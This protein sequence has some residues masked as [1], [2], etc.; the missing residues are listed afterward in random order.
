[1]RRYFLNEFKNN[2]TRKART[3][4]CNSLHVRDTNQDLIIHKFCKFRNVLNVMH[5]NIYLNCFIELISQC[6][7]KY[8]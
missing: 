5:I 6:I 3:Y 1:M 4:I 2:K 7:T 8:Y